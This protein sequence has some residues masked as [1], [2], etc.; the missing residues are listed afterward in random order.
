MALKR[1]DIALAI[2]MAVYDAISLTRRKAFLKEVKALK[3]LSVRI[4]DGLANEEMT[5]KATY[6]TCYHD[7]PSNQIKCSDTMVEI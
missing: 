2:P 7:D 6:H 4:N 5:V 3:A 1:F